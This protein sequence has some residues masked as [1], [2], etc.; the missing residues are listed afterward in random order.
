MFCSIS[1]EVPQE[2]VVS[3]RSGAVFERRLALQLAQQ[4]GLDP[5]SGQPLS[6]ADLVLVKGQ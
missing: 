6:E 4:G 3:S 5:L 2:P 1:G